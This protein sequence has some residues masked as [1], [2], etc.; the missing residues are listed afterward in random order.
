MC[1]PRQEFKTQL[2]NLTQLDR[3]RII[4]V[5]TKNYTDPFD[6]HYMCKLLL[7]SIATYRKLKQIAIVCAGAQQ[8]H[9][10]LI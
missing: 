8:R 1:V 5:S 6:M 7:M 9:Y 10:V 3:L 4:A 2:Q